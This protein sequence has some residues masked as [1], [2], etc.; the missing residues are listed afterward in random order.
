MET[1]ASL[2]L[3]GSLLLPILLWPIG[4][5]FAVAFPFMAWS[6]LK[7]LKAIRVAL[8]RLADQAERDA[9]VERPNEVFT[10]TSPISMR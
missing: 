3:A 1:L 7:Q 6:A 8:D 2:A 4:A 10:R 9:I 5:F